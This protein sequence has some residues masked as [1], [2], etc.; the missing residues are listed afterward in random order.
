MSRRP[1]FG[2]HKQQPPPKRRKPAE[3]PQNEDENPL[4][5]LVQRYTI[6][7]VVERQE[8]ES[9]TA[10]SIDLKLFG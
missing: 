4:F 5:F 2:W 6:R 7:I 10:L 3:F 9:R 8:L 1:S